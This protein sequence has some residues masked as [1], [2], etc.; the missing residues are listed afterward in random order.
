MGS[1]AY[2]G[3]GG[4][5]LPGVGGDGGVSDRGAFGGAG[6]SAGNAGFAGGNPED[7]GDPGAGGGG[8]WG[9][10]GGDAYGETTSSAGLGGKAVDLNGYTVTWQG[11]FDTD[12]SNHIYGAVA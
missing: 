2:G 4:R 9:A 11:E 6:G 8:G 10:A 5:I 1:V 7:T 12:F 3:G